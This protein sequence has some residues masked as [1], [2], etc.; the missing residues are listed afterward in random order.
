MVPHRLLPS[1]SVTI[2]DINAMSLRELKGLARGMHGSQASSDPGNEPAG[3]KSAASKAPDTDDQCLNFQDVPGRTG[4]CVVFDF[5]SRRTSAAV[6]AFCRK[7]GLKTKTHFRIDQVQN[8]C[9]DIAAVSMVAMRMAGDDFYEVEMDQLVGFN[10]EAAVRNV[11][12]TINAPHHHVG[13]W[14]QAQLEGDQIIQI[15]K[16]FNPDRKLRW[17]RGPLPMDVFTTYMSGK[18][19]AADG[20]INLVAVTRK[21][22]LSSRHALVCRG[23]PGAP[24]R[25]GVGVPQRRPTAPTVSSA[26]IDPSPCFLPRCGNLW[27]S[28]LVPPP[29]LWPRKACRAAGAV[30]R[31]HGIARARRMRGSTLLRRC[32]SSHR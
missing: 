15:V 17:L 13:N 31:W 8:A 2:Q 5:L 16:A 9:G 14:E 19:M 3:T 21:G 12:D 25:A 27:R 10:N 18:L 29:H 28:R 32:Y 23:I 4:E 6:A 26:H 7:V 30:L 1:V 20:E 24:C 11:R 22:V